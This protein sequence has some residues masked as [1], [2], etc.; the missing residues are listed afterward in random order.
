LRGAGKIKMT[1]AKCKI[2]IQ[3]SK[4]LGETVQCLRKSILNF[5]L[6][7]CVFPFEL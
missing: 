2:E 6:Q 7:L 5:E 4:F 1:S 3:K